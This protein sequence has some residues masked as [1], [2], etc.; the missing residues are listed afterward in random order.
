MEQLPRRLSTE[1]RSAL[2]VSDRRGAGDFRLGTTSAGKISWGESFHT[3]PISVRGHQTRGTATPLNPCGCVQLWE[4]QM[5][6]NATSSAMKKRSNAQVGSPYGRRHSPREEAQG[7]GSAPNC[8]NNFRGENLYSK[9]KTEVFPLRT[10]PPPCDIPSGCCFFTGPWTVTRSSLRRA[11]RVAAFCR[12]L[13][14]VLLLVSFPRSRSPVVW[15]VGAVLDVAGCAVCA[16]AAPVVA[17]WGCAGCCRG[18][19]TVFAVHLPPLYAPLPEFPVATAIGAH[20]LDC[21]F[22]CRCPVAG[23]RTDTPRIF[24]VSPC[25]PRPISHRRLSSTAGLRVVGRVFLKGE[26]V[27]GGWG[28]GG[29][30]GA[31]NGR[32]ASFIRG[33]GGILDKTH[34][35]T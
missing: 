1:P 3:R 4:A 7:A 29:V 21:C 27:V 30:Q 11:R 32:Q 24:S 25:T 13:R 22:P 10:P 17:H 34:P 14:P 15:C 16:S 8:A 6:N 31:S 28:G 19:L 33:G 35:P 18:R 5:L 23:I 12:P 2:P 26:G 9:L 20:L